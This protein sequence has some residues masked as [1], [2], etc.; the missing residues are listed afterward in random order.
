MYVLQE[1]YSRHYLGDIAEKMIRICPTTGSSHKTF[2]YSTC[3]G[4]S[5]LHHKSRLFQKV[6]RDQGY[7]IGSGNGKSLYELIN[8]LVITQ[9]LRRMALCFLSCAPTLESLDGNESLRGSRP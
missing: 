4:T 5:D 2:L 7:K 6:L 3:A 9:T 8:L 1:Q